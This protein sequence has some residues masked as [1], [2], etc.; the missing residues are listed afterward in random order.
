MTAG[1]WL[2]TAV[3]EER[4]RQTS[5]EASRRRLIS[6]LSSPSQATDDRELRFVTNAL[7]LQLFDVMND[8]GRVAELRA[9]AVETFQIAR[10]L[11]WPEEP[12]AAAQWLVRL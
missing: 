6:A 5:T 9:V 4:L 7:E 8:E 11:A 12:L 1:T 10:T 2:R 3:G